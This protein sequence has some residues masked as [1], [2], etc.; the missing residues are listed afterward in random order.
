[1]AKIIEWLEMHQ[2]PCFYKKHFGVA[3][4][5]CGMQRSFIELLKGHVYESFLLYP[6]L[7]PI[8]IMLLFLILHVFFKF[9]KGGKILKYLFIFTF[10]LMVINYILNLIF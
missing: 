10:S 7:M 2:Q 4:P 8:I 6:A 3:C 9:E 1:M 5:G